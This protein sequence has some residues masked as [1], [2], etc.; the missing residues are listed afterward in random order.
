MKISIDGVNCQFPCLDAAT[1]RGLSDVEQTPPH[2]GSHA[3]RCGS[4]ASGMPHLGVLKCDR[5]RFPARSCLGSTSACPR[6]VVAAQLHSMANPHPTRRIETCCFGTK[7]TKGKDASEP[8]KYCPTSS[9]PRSSAFRSDKQCR[10]RAGHGMQFG[11][12]GPLGYA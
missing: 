3:M 10:M 2:R 5:L 8:E 12:L 11:P 6:P 7:L 9:V 1:G 4:V